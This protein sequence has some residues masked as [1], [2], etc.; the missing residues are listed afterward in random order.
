MQ[1]PLLDLKAQYAQ[2]K[3]EVEPAI[4]EVCRSQVCV[5]GPRLAEFETAIAAYCGC[6]HAI[7]VSSGTDA[8]LLALMALGAGAGDEV[9]VPAFTFG[10][11]A[12]VVA[13]VCATPVFVD[14]DPDTF[15]VTA[16][17][18]AAKITPKTRGIIVVHLFGQ[19]VDMS[20]VMN[21][22]RR[23]GIFVIE[24]A[25]QSIGASQGGTKCGSFGEYGCFSFYPTKNLGCFGDGGLVT[26]N[27]ADSDATA[28]ML[29]NH[30]QHAQY[31]YK[32]I[33]GNFR[34][35][36]VQ[37]AV[38]NVKL[39]Y[40]DQWSG[41]RAEHAA[42]YNRLLAGLPVRTP[43]IAAG[44]VSVFN[45]YTIRAPQRD[46][47]RAYLSE[48]GVGSG[49]YYPTG[50]HLE[51][52]FK[53]LGHRPGDLPVTEQLCRE[54]ISLPVHAEL[55]AEQIEYAAGRIRAFYAS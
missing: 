46:K 44:N 39:K 52:C 49:V 50:L 10:A 33:G 5:G 1:V 54:V 35:D 20:S 15:N 47:L 7:G 22:A 41:K 30:G 16:D 51:E 2:I 14:V 28:R 26:T 34:M 32:M 37:A 17:L 29:R 27:N 11:T 38:L 40:L 45:Q 53:A 21:L 13:R 25:C 55:R 18:I 36:A 24:D 19:M 43:V 31:G 23:K 42:M 12:E 9:I 3:D 4:L 8:L 6:R 48:Q